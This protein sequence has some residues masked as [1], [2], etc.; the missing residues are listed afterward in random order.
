[1]LATF[2]TYNKPSGAYAD[3]RMCDFTAKQTHFGA[4]GPSALNGNNA[5][6]ELILKECGDVSYCFSGI[7]GGFPFVWM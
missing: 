1:M 7:A 6:N 3:D 5:F 2:S 4:L